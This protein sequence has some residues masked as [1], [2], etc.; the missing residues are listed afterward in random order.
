MFGVFRGSVLFGHKKAIHEIAPEESFLP[1]VIN[2]FGRLIPFA[3]TI[4][5]VHI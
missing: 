2:A 4:H 5:G 3:R 1:A